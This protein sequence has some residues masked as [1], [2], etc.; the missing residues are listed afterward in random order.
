MPSLTGKHETI[1]V[2]TYGSLMYADIFEKVTGCLPVSLPATA[3]NWQRHGLAN[4]TYPGAMPSRLDKAVIE[5]VL[6]LDLSQAALSALDDFEGHE[7][8]RTEIELIAANGL[9][10]R[11][12]IYEWLLH[13]QV[14]GDWKVEDFEK[15]HRQHFVQIHG[16][17]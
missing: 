2:F 5:G 3:R 15:H 1:N 8:C 17:R 14:R 11:A 16:K 13:D 12:Y 7:Y 9:A 6:W 4:R 10:H